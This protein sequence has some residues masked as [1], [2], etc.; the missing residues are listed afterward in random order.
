MARRVSVIAALALLAA[1]GGSDVPLYQDLGS[2]RRAVTTRSAEAQRWFDQGLRLAYAFNQAEAVRSFTR[3]TVLDPSCAMCWWGIA[4]AS[5]PNI[6]IPMDS[7]GEVAAYAAAQRAWAVRDGATDVERGLVEA[8]VRRYGA[9]PMAARAARDSAY[10]AAMAA[11]A[12][13]FPAD[14]DVQV[15]AAEAAMLLR[16]WDYWRPDGSPY[17]GTTELVAKLETVV[18]RDSTHPG[19][20][21]FFIHAVEKFEPQRAVACAE[22][23]AAL[24]PGAGHLV[25][26]PAHI[27]FRVGRYA[28]A[29]AANEHAS[30]ADSVYL[31]GRRDGGLYALF[32]TPHN[33]HFR[34]A[35]AMMEGRYA[36]ALDAARAS[37]RLTP[38]ANVQAVPPAELYVP[39]PLY[40][41][42]RFGKWDEILREPPPAAPELRFTKGIWHYARGLAFTATGRGDSARAEAD[43]LHAI[44]SA[45]PEDAIIGLNAGRALLGIADH[46]LQGE[47]AARAGDTPGAVR[48]FDAAIALEDGLTYDEPPPW[49]YPVR[50][51]LGAALLAARRAADAEAVYREDLR[52]YPEN[53]W[54]LTGLRE[55]L[56]AQGK[57][58]AADSAD[59]AF[60]RAWARADVTINASRL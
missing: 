45:Y 32:Y 60:R 4:Y 12:E 6:N 50:Q 44:A 59:A 22:R 58:T 53:G 54:S 9:E 33:H 13:R 35:A 10:A 41:L 28:D 30:H 51:S 23:L 56:R 15:L 2:F 26:M 5:G 31:E 40:V 18:A 47:M 25:H 8:Q 42:A 38:L 7:A 39:V 17:P 49:Y 19:A 21:H 52:R 36:A 43:S 57:A 37:A 16:P 34:A 3:A 24:M 20:C 1:C 48:H 27:Y 46:A 29:V 14:D 55:A 11:L